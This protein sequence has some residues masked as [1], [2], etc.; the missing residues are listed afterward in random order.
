MRTRVVTQQQQGNGLACQPLTQTSACTVPV[1]CLV[2]EWGNWGACTGG[3]TGGQT[4][5]SRVVT[6]QQQGNGLAC[7]GL[8][9]TLA[10]T[11]FDVLPAIGD[12]CNQTTPCQT[13]LICVMANNPGEYNKYRCCDPSVLQL[14][15]AELNV[16]EI[17]DPS[18]SLCKHNLSCKQSGDGSYRCMHSGLGDCWTENNFGNIISKANPSIL[19]PYPCRFPFVYKGVT[20]Y[21]CTGV[22][23]PNGRPW[24]SL[25]QW[26]RGGHHMAGMWGFCEQENPSCFQ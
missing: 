21:K 12:D 11:V 8:T 26:S 13:G 23:S 4:M 1:D 14:I 17:C 7:P 18:E 20:Y 25:N 5:R 9:E 22:D 6:Q 19:L 15:P 24:C 2:S 16:N 10:C 3:Q